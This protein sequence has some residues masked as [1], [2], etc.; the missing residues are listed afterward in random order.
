VPAPLVDK[1][2]VRLFAI[3]YLAGFAALIVLRFVAVPVVETGQ[4][5]S[6]SA[7]TTAF[8]DNALA[9]LLAS[10]AIFA[11]ARWLGIA[12]PSA[13]LNIVAPS[14]IRSILDDASASAGEWTFRGSV[15]RST[16]ANI[17]PRLE[18]RAVA[19]NRTIRFTLFILD[20]S[21][22]AMLDRYA[23]ARRGR[24]AVTS[25]QLAEELWASILSATNAHLR[26]SNLDVSILLHSSLAFLRYDIWDTGALATNGYRTEPAILAVGDSFL[27]KAWKEDLRIALSIAT[28]V[29]ISAAEAVR[30]ASDVPPALTALG[31]TDSAAPVGPDAA[32]R[33]WARVSGPVDPFATPS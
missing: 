20:P 21:D 2:Q 1:Q 28:R 13:D 5:P 16:I 14:R 32:A 27:L 10:A 11:V 15:G 9:A 17:L 30:S 29:D 12:A 8:L 25:D 23:A 18:G 31:L 24:R 4:L 22:T 33:I 26:T 3:A 6:W 7:A 19:E